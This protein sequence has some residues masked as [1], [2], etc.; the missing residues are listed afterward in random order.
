MKYKRYLLRFFLHILLLFPIP[1][2]HTP[3]ANSDWAESDL[4]QPKRHSLRHLLPGESPDEYSVLSLDGGGFRG[5]GTLHMLCKIEEETGHKIYELYDAI[6]G[7]S[8]GGLLAL[9]MANGHSAKECLGIYEEKIPIIFCRRWWQ[10]LLNPFGIFDQFYCSQNLEKVISGFVNTNHLKN[11]K[12]PVGLVCAND[13]TRELVFL[14]SVDA[15]KEGDA[16]N[17]TQKSAALATTAAPLYF[18]LFTSPHSKGEIRLVDGGVIAN[19]PGR[20]GYNFAKKIW[21]NDAKIRLTSFGT[22]SS[23]L[24][25][26]ASREGLLSFLWKNNPPDYFAEHATQKTHQELKEDLGPHYNRFNFTL[27]RRMDLDDATAPNV[28]EVST[29]ATNRTLEGDFIAYIKRKQGAPLETKPLA[30]AQVP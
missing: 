12:V 1:F 2:I 25:K 9:L 23:P 3:F 20:Q 8:T 30:L 13:D 21:G 15:K 17:L 29:L 6:V 18:D 7:T 11:V 16:S 27:K 26:L 5:I 28:R 4:S 24:S 14:N 10:R 19:H 22:G